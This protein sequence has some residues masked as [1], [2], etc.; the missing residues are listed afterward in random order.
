MSIVT[1]QEIRVGGSVLPAGTITQALSVAD[2]AALVS[3]GAAMPFPAP[4]MPK[5]SYGLSGPLV[6]P[7]NPI[8]VGSYG[9]SIANISSASTQDLRTVTTGNKALNDLRFGSWLPSLSNG[10][11]RMVFNGGVSG[12]N[13]SQMLARESAGA[14]ATRKSVQ[15]ARDVGCQVLVF[16]PPVNDLGSFTT[17]TAQSTIDAAVTTAHN[18]IRTLLRKARAFGIWPVVVSFG[19]YSNT[20][21]SAADNAVRRAA[22]RAWE[23]AMRATIAAAA[24]GLGKFVDTGMI[25]G[26]GDGEWLTG[27]S[28]D[29]V[30]PDG[31]ACR[32]RYQPVVDA[33]LAR[34][35]VSPPT[36]AL[37]LTSINFMDNA[38]LSAATSGLAT[39][40]TRAA[41]SGTATFANQIVYAHDRPWQEVVFTP[42]VLDGN[43][44][45]NCNIDINFPVTGG[46]PFV[47]VSASD[48]IAG[49]CD[50]YIDDGLGGPPP[51]F[52][53]A[54]RMRMNGTATVYHDAFSFDP[55]KS[56][57][58]NFDE[59]VMLHICT[60]PV[61]AVDASAAM[62]GCL[63]QLYALTAQTAKTV[64][65][66]VGNIRAGKLP[67]TY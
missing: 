41:G 39:R 26:N 64:R 59:P 54:A 52:T 18:N 28:Y 33:I 25:C 53:V 7:V 4:V 44:N 67:S 66:V 65:M 46:S 21:A 8:R 27:Y 32:R 40:I 58:L 34:F 55:V 24:G 37:P 20:G 45:V 6:A 61:Q 43:G 2:N 9:D 56:P 50:I 38:D 13:T 16:S 30:H 62:T 36:W 51:V 48:L 1:K 14:S 23:S 60:A 49:E 57:K 15:D 19:P 47:A 11:I 5:P 3:R 63:M 35:G 29:G 22:M 12:D 10:A 17:A 42:T 31:V